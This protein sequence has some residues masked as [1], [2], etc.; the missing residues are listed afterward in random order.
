MRFGAAG[1]AD[2]VGPPINYHIYKKYNKS[3]TDQEFWVPEKIA[4]IMGDHIIDLVHAEQY[5]KKGIENAEIGT[6]LGDLSKKEVFG[7]PSE[8]G[9][10]E[11]AVKEALPVPQQPPDMELCKDQAGF[12]GCIDVGGYGIAPVKLLDQDKTDD[13][14]KKADDQEHEKGLIGLV[15]TAKTYQP[16]D[17]G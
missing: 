16:C 14:G 8:K 6:E 15:D 9:N 5:D 11:E 4:V 13:L 17:N 7:C 10:N 12:Y 3:D 1:Y 2:L